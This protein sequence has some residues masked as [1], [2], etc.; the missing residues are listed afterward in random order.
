MNTPG[1]SGD[2]RSPFYRNLFEHWAG[3]DFHPVYYS[4]ERVEEATAVRFD[5]RPGR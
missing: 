3:D 4:R 1:Q 5:L 2:V